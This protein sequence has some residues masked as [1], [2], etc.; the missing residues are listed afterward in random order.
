LL[1]VLAA[2]L[3]KKSCTVVIAISSSI[4]VVAF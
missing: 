4:D 3:Q 2:S 1:S